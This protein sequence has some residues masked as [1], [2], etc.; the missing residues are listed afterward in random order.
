MQPPMQCKLANAKHQ[1]WPGQTLVTT[2]VSGGMLPAA[3]YVPPN[4][5]GFATM[6]NVLLF[7]HGFY[8]PSVGV[9]QFRQ[10]SC[11]RTGP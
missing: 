6:L 10:Y 5:D 1:I 11:V 3:V 8:V 4:H 2:S 9:D 7:L